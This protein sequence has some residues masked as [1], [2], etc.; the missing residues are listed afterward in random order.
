VPGARQRPDRQPELRGQ[1]PHRLMPGRRGVLP[2]RDDHGAGPGR[3]PGR[4]ERPEH[5]Q[6]PAHRAMVGRGLGA[7][8]GPAVERE[9]ER[10]RPAR[11]VGAADLVKQARQ[12]GSHGGFVQD[13]RGHRHAGRRQRQP[14]GGAAAH[15]RDE[16]AAAVRPQ[17]VHLGHQVPAARAV[18]AGHIEAVQQRDDPPP[19]PAGR[20]GPVN[21]DHAGQAHHRLLRNQRTA[22]TPPGTAKASPRASRSP[23]QASC[24]KARPPKYPSSGADGALSRADESRGDE[25]PAS[26]E[27]T[28]R[29]CRTWPRQP[30]AA[31]RRGPGPARSPQRRPA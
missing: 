23:F 24:S 22:S 31:G 5:G 6:V 15:A 14:Q 12:Q 16:R 11:F 25:D 28:A 9:A 26:L 30:A 2:D 29:A 20:G 17:R 1:P 7:G 10:R 3:G 21:Q 19:H 18:G 27:P 4:L 8:P 13:G